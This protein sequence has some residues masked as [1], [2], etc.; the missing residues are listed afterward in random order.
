MP[1]G[2]TP[3]LFF[4]FL[5]ILLARS[6]QYIYRIVQEVHLPLGIQKPTNPCDPPRQELS[7]D[8]QYRRNYFLLGQNC[9]AQ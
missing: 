4:L 3:L 7:S 5:A 2:I 6:T 9:D 8:E 1:K